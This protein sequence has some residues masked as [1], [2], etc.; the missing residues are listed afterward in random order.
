[1]VSLGWLL[2]SKS[3]YP[4][5]TRK[6]TVTFYDLALKTVFFCFVLFV[7]V[8]MKYCLCLEE[9][10]IGFTTLGGRSCGGIPG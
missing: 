5:R 7:E 3:E 8:V 9:G 10:D 4:K 6:K 2:D 1:M